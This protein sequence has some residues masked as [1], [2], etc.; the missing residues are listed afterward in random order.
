ML[1][2]QILRDEPPKPRSL[3][4][5][6]PRDLQTICLKCLEKEPS[7]R[8]QTAAELADDLR[9]HLRGEPIHAQP[10]TQAGRLYRWCRRQPAIASLLAT[11]LIALAAG[12]FAGFF[13]GAI[14]GAES[15]S[16]L[17]YR[18]LSQIRVNRLQGADGYLPL[19]WQQLKEARAIDTPN[20]DVDELRQ[21]AVLWL[22]DFRNHVPVTIDSPELTITVGALHPSG[23]LLAIGHQDGR[24]E[25]HDPATGASVGKI[26][27][28]GKSIA[29]L[30]FDSVGKHLLSVDAGGQVRASLVTIPVQPAVP[31]TDIFRIDDD[32]ISF[33]FVPG[34]RYLAAYNSK[35]VSLW[36]TVKRD[37][38]VRVT[39][40]AK[41]NVRFALASPDGKWLAA[42]VSTDGESAGDR[43]VLWNAHSGDV[44]NEVAVN[45][46]S[47]YPESLAFSHDSKM[48]AFG[49]EGMSL[50]NVPDLTPYSFF[51]GD[52][53][54]ALAFSPDNQH[55]ALAQIRGTVAI[56]SMAANTKIMSLSHPR[57]P[58]TPVA[59]EL[60]RFSADGRYLVSIKKHSARIWDLRAP[61][62][63]MVLAGHTSNVP[64]LAFSPNERFLASGSNDASVRIWRTS[65]GELA[66][67][68]LEFEGKI[69]QVAFSPKGE[70]LA[71][72]EWPPQSSSGTPAV[73]YVSESADYSKLTRISS[74]LLHRIYA[75]DFS[76]DGHFLAVSGHGLQLWRIKNP[77]ATEGE[78][79]LSEVVTLPGSRSLFLKFSPDSKLLAWADEWRKVRVFD[80]EA[81]QELDFSA[82]MHIGWHGFVF[83]EGC[84][85]FVAS[86]FSFEVWDVRKR[87]RMFPLGKPGEFSSP[88]I[89]ATA[90]G[91]YLAGLHPSD[92]VAFWDVKARKRLFHFRP[93]RSEVW[94]LA[95]SPGGSKLAV[96]LS[97]GGVAV[98]DLKVFN[99]ALAELDLAWTTRE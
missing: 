35:S 41:R 25:L 72:V 27:G 71:A 31:A 96:G 34:A 98:W 82:E 56:W 88:H 30:S 64:T 76:P 80:V 74:N 73:F 32:H 52:A 83:V 42:A 86:N 66:Y 10:I 50:L 5:G 26:A 79:Q 12:V 2:L 7:R 62:E 14:R 46:G 92:T 58:N 99:R 90:K 18:L 28:R 15:R 6:I 11:L 45:R 97:D 13:Y 8:Y 43:V 54:K 87:E 1:V 37:Q 40:P 78:I 67:P 44:E 3:R 55:L 85:G 65:D 17:Y 21:E 51:P 39:A 89:A 20:L 81:G 29:A 93:E 4:A 77:V 9:R 33:A 59:G 61:K 47:A 60:T 94:S 69:Q 57:P 22:G 19:A 84:L 36:D 16:N 23:N 70:R 53:I 48:F 49:G 24:V 68:P 38:L 75:V 63:R 95:F 91:D